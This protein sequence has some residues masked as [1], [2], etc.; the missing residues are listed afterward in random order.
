MG[1]QAVIDSLL[2]VDSCSEDATAEVARSAGATVVDAKTFLERAGFSFDT[3][4]GGALWTG[5]CVLDTDLVV[6]VDADLIS[7][8]STY[9]ERLIEPL[10]NDDAGFAK[11]YYERPLSGPDG[12]VERGGRATELA[13][14]PLINMLFP[15]LANIV[16]PL[17]GEYA[18]KRS[19]L[20]SLPFSTGYGVDIGLL[21][22]ASLHP[23]ESAVQVDLGERKHRNRDLLSLGVTA[24]HVMQAILRRAES[25]GRMK[26]A[27]DLATVFTQFTDTGEVLRSLDLATEE[28]PPPDALTP[29]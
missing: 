27:D 5:V 19:L 2:V 23:D 25:Y 9:V 8:V 22:D 3:G 7:S 4:K 18:G 16:Q 1:G 10:I 13:A 21:I 17:S 24:H 12:V 15:E 6:F 29:Q 11:G 20:A 28:L 26:L 14:R